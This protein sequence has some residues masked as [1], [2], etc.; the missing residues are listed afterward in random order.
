M[1]VEHEH[2]Y[3]G[4]QVGVV[5]VG[6]VVEQRAGL[7]QADVHGGGGDGGRVEREEGDVLCFGA[8]LFYGF[9]GVL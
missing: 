2:R 4:L 9:S 7:R 5:V 6:E 3:A 8:G 1:F